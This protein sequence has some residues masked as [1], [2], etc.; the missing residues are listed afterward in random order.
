MNTTAGRP[1]LDPATAIEFA[2]V[3]LIWGATWLVIKGQLGVVPPVWS[4]A[5]RFTAA[6]LCLTAFT[7][8]TGRWRW[9][10]RTG[11]GFALAVGVAQFV[12]NF[13]LVYLAETRLASGLVA[14]VF[15]LLIVPNAIFARIFLKSPVTPR[16]IVGATIGIAGLVLLFAPDLSAPA[17]RAQTAEGV[18]LVGA[19]VLCASIANVL[20]AGGLGRS[21]PALPTLAVAMAYGAAIDIVFAVVTAGRPAWD[22]RPEYVAGLAYLALLASVVAFSVY[23][24]L[25]RR[26]GPATAAYSSIVVPVLA[27]TLSTVFE[28]YRWTAMAAAGAALSLAGLVVALGGRRAVVS[29][30]TRAVPPENP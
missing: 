6:S 14:L 16:F 8:A 24:R 29:G 19:G 12:M 3:T 5:Y 1:R 30:D 27:M 25:I 28:G 17:G 11:H 7:V 26:I 15:A 2:L 10:T 9:P 18:L 21:L 13:N 23:Y 22:P 4:V 20:Q